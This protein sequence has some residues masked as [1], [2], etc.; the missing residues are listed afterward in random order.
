MR[1]S[2]NS[3]LRQDFLGEILSWNLPLMRDSESSKYVAEIANSST[4][5][6]KIK[7]SSLWVEVLL[8]TT[9]NGSCKQDLQFTQSRHTERL[10]TLWWSIPRIFLRLHFIWALYFSICCVNFLSMKRTLGFIRV[11]TN[12]LNNSWWA[13]FAFAVNAN[14]FFHINSSMGQGP[15]A[16]SR[17]KFEL[18]K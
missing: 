7:V 11:T 18:T 16:K 6:R 1:K 13:K 9:N 14:P 10:T 12:C 15:S 2:F 4:K 17:V 8:I 3:C 5:I